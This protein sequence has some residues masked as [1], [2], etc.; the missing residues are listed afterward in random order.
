MGQ[1]PDRVAIVPT[2]VISSNLVDA[3]S[4]ALEVA[5]EAAIFSDFFEIDEQGP[6]SR[7]AALLDQLVTT[8]RK[9]CATR[10]TETREASIAIILEICN[11]VQAGITPEVLSN[12]RPSGR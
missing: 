8:M 3:L 12:Q 11:K 1:I 5:I 4:G 6:V 2:L 9:E 10:P 7:L